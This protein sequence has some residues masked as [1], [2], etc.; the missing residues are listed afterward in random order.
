MYVCMYIYLF[1]CMYV[2][3]YVPS[4]ERDRVPDTTRSLT[5]TEWIFE[6]GISGI[7]DQ[8][9]AAG[10]DSLLTT[11]GQRVAYSGEQVLTAEWWWTTAAR[12][13][14]AVQVEKCICKVL[15]SRQSSRLWARRTGCMSTEL[16]VESDSWNSGE[17]FYV[18]YCFN[19]SA[20]CANKQ[21]TR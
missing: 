20:F 17:V 10:Q 15:F 14:S 9:S 7:S 13:H 2:C 6:K 11:S 4:R 1:V 8:H 18:H 16:S 21:L 19:C 12:L 5:A 3:M